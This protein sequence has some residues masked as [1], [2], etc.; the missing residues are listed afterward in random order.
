MTSLS[1]EFKGSLWTELVQELHRRTEGIHESGAFL[2]G[3]VTGQHRVVNAVVYYDD[4]DAEAYETYRCVLRAPAFGTLW[5]RCSELGLSVVADVHVHP[6]AA[7]QSAVDRTNPMIARPGHIAIIL[8]NFAEPPVQLRELGIY[9]Y[10]GDY[11]WRKLKCSAQLP[12]LVL[13]GDEPWTS[14]I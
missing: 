6:F 4:L 9:E 11:S 3:Q 2:L 1:L 7:V 14:A 5:K 12:V 8:P 10:L 13:E